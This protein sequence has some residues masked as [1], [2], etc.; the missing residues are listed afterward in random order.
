MNN[1][2]AILDSMP[3]PSVFYTRYWG[4]LPFVVRGAVPVSVMQGLIEADELAALAGEDGVRSRLVNT[5]DEQSTWGCQFGPFDEEDFQTQPP[6]KWSLLVQNVEQYHPET[7]ALLRC[8]DFSPRWLLDDIMVSYATPGG[9]VG[10]HMDSYHVFLVQGAGQRQWTVANAPLSPEQEI[11]VD[12]LDLKVLRDDFVGDTVTVSCGDVI[13][14]PPRFAHAGVTLE[15]SLTYSVGFLGPKLSDLFMGYGQYLSEFDALDQPYGAAS[16]GMDDTGFTV[17]SE[18]VQ[19]FQTLLSGNVNGGHFAQWL[20]EF[21]A[22]SSN[23]DIADLGERDDILSVDTLRAHMETG[24][25][26]IKPAYVKLV[27]VG[28]TNGDFYV[29]YGGKAVRMDNSLSALVDC[30]CSEQAFGLSDI[31]EADISEPA[32][33]M[34]ATL[35][36][37]QA[38]EWS[39]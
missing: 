39:L 35:Y 37:D 7:A 17:S 27:I 24:R 19:N 36:N 6:E 1:A 22:G 26:L 25:Q 20:T 3:P 8:F 18:A 30:M 12:G 4:R 9:T 28:A 10:P 2:L 11:Y 5:P 15:S 14:I 34:L 13:Y 31:S 21:F 29:G 23:E 16:L 38:L 33:S 32:L